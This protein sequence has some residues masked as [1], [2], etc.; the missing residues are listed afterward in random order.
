[1]FSA[2]CSYY[3]TAPQIRRYAV[4]NNSVLCLC[5]VLLTQLVLQLARNLKITCNVE[6]VA[7]RTTST[8]E[9]NATEVIHRCPMHD[10]MISVVLCLGFC[11]GT[12]MTDR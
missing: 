4:Y 1:M 11:T 10:I 2:Q 8:S 6:H 3:C 5:C 7:V 12:S 9:H